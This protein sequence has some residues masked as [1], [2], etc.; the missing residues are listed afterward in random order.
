M[1]ASGIVAISVCAALAAAA[2]ASGQ[3]V[4]DQGAARLEAQVDALGDAFDARLAAASPALA[5]IA[6]RVRISAF[7]SGVW[8]DASA[9]ALVC[10]KHRQI[11]D[12]RFFADVLLAEDV[13]PGERTWLRSAAVSVEWDL[14]RLGYEDDDLGEAYVELQGLGDSGWWN[15]Q[16]G[17]FQIPVGENYLRFSKG[18]R[19]N[20]FIS[21]TVAG[22]WWWDEG[23]K[24]YGA[25]ARGRYGYVASLTNG[26]TPRDFGLDGGD[27]YTLK[28]FVNPAPWLHLS[29][30]GLYSGGMGDDESPA[31]AALWL[32]ESWARGFGSG[33]PLPNFVNGVAL[34]DGPGRLDDTLYLGADAV[35]THPAGARLWLSYGSYAID[36][37]GPAV[38]DR[39]LHGW[40]AELVLEGRLLRPELA[41]FYLALRAN[42]L[43]T[44]DADEGY[45]LD[46]RSGWTVGYN[47][48]A[49]EGY[50][51]ALGWRLTRWTTVKLEYSRQHLTQVR[52]AGP[53]QDADIVGAELAVFF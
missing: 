51:A 46:V 4:L 18:A 42:G 29:V 17:R 35:F 15:V 21:N 24:L 13:G 33:S 37:S 53:A 23:V 12:A 22:A 16:L 19:D 11:W 40:I 43:G 26:E 36:S 45:L 48:R 31:N 44:Y 6:R 3:G 41:R 30:S 7:A 32:G 27:Q 38:Y 9:E 34:P 39:T 49:L 52:G 8:F 10:C 14:Y 2:A 28:L 50:S 47:A 20:P 25:D 1:R 5:E